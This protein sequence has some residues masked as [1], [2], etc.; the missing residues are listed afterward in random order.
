MLRSTATHGSKSDIGERVSELC[1]K[2]VTVIHNTRQVQS[3][4]L[5]RNEA[6]Y[7]LYAQGEHLQDEVNLMEDSDEKTAHNQ[8]LASIRSD[9]K[10]K[11]DIRTPNTLEKLT[12]IPRVLVFLWTV[13]LGCVLILLLLPLRWMHPLLR[14]YANIQNDALPMDILVKLHSRLCCTAAGI[15]VKTQGGE[16][17]KGPTIMMFSHVSNLDSMVLVGVCPL[18]CKWIGKKVI[19]LVPIF[20]WMLAAIGG[21]PICRSDRKQA[22]RQLKSLQEKYE[23]YG[24]SL[25]ISPEGTRSCSGLLREFKKGPFYLWEDTK[26]PITPAL[27]FGAYELWPPAQVV[28]SP[29]LVVVRFGAAV[30]ATE[31]AQQPHETQIQT[32][33]AAGGDPKLRERAR[34]TLRAAML[35]GLTTSYPTQAGLPLSVLGAADRAAFAVEYLA[36]LAGLLYASSALAGLW[37]AAFAGWGAGQVAGVCLAFTAVVDGF[38]YATL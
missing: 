4:P 7:S 13:F 14:K 27:I 36:L 37:A 11:L 33:A 22:V 34:V 10:M 32:P 3:D 6:I 15:V 28:P 16:K 38:I 17:M 19:F 21:Q 23:V 30:M 2:V 12:T 8:K 24:R 25:A 31:A 5:G 35:R 20:G 1:D 29:G 9:P 18:L 26:L